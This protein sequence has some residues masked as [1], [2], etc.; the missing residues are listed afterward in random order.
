ASKNFLMSQMDVA[1]E[2]TLLVGSPV[3]HG[4]LD[5]VRN[6]V[7][8]WALDL[9]SRGIVGD[10]MSF[11]LQ[12]KSTASQVTYQITNNIGSMQNSQIQQDSQGASQVQNITLEQAD[13]MQFLDAIKSARDDLGLDQDSKDE[14]D[15]EI[16]TIE[17][18]LASPKPKK[19]IITES[20]KS[21]RN[22][23]EGITG[24]IIATALLTQLSALM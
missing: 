6:A 7:L 20:L 18:Q 13:I 14:L 16:A 8:D 5:H 19:S 21:T 23:L 12:E 10:G 1:L 15:T 22:I 2:P 3:L 17:L 4:I 11:S 9:E 24:S